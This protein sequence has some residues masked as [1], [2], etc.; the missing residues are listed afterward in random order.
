MFLSLISLISLF[1]L[2]NNSNPHAPTLERTSFVEVGLRQENL[3]PR[4]VVH[5]F[6]PSTWEAKAGRSLCLNQLGL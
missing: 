6:N 4:V 3:E 5:A 1:L 2:L